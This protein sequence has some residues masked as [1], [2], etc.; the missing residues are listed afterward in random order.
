[1]KEIFGAH[2]SHHLPSKNKG[3]VAATDHLRPIFADLKAMG[4]KFKYGSAMLL[5]L[6]AAFLTSSHFLRWQCAILKADFSRD[7]PASQARSL[8]FTAKGVHLSDYKNLTL[9]L[10]EE[11]AKKSVNI[12]LIFSV[13]S[14][15]GLFLQLKGDGLSA[16]VLI[17]QMN[18]GEGISKGR[19]RIELH[20]QP[21]ILK[22]VIDGQAGQELDVGDSPFMEIMLV[23]L[24]S[25]IFIRSITVDDFSKEPISHF[26]FVPEFAKPHFRWTAICMLFFFWL[27]LTMLIRRRARLSPMQSAG[28]TLFCFTP[29]WAGLMFPLGIP[30]GPWI[31]LLTLISIALF[32][33]LAFA[34]KIIPLRKWGPFVLLFPALT[35]WGDCV[36]ISRESLLPLLAVIGTVAG[37]ALVVF[38]LRDRKSGLLNQVAAS[39]FVTATAAFGNLPV[40]SQN[41]CGAKWSLGFSSMLMLFLFS[42]SRRDKLRAYIPVIL[43]VALSTLIYGEM[44]ARSS[45]L[46]DNGSTLDTK[47]SLHE[48]D[49]L[50]FLQEQVPD[51]AQE[52]LQKFSTRFRS[53][54]TTPAKP[55]GIFRVM[56]LGGSNTYGNGMPSNRETFSGV[57]ADDCLSKKT[58]ARVEVITAGFQGYNLFMLTQVF[59]G[60][61]PSF[62]PDILILYVNWID[63]RIILGPFTFHELQRMNRRTKNSLIRQWTEKH[64]IGLD[65]DNIG[66]TTFTIQQAL[67]N[68]TLYRIGAEKITAAKAHTLKPLSE[69]LGALKDINP[70][71]EYRENLRKLISLCKQNNIELVLV[72]EL[73]PWNDPG[74]NSKIRQLETIMEEE[75]KR[76]GFH[77]LNLD[78]QMLNNEDR[79]DLFFTKPPLISHLNEAGHKL[80]GYTLCDYLI[81]KDLLP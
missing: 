19:H 35:Q 1:M 67:R 18:N 50:T 11:A 15:E 26:S 63:S 33:A 53:G 43:F 61:G 81:A 17:D 79:F 52:S 22:T 58:T 44:Y 60:F 46:N 7:Y 57:L 49:F 32:L 6:A 3:V 28:H 64:R 12:T 30:L 23:T 37:F 51:F 48:H 27:A 40:F 34:H 47:I 72:N 55:E 42:F 74:S 45:T 38:A 75:G 10:P 8:P 70:V 14:F 25:D 80:V 78:G 41:Q 59:E 39:L 76:A 77:Y 21:S 65:S 16:D 24:E 2:E 73:N 69:T 36:G 56:V 62:S 31:V 20:L 66:S 5:I 9:P 4:G 71:S 54:E 13:E 29:L 68:F